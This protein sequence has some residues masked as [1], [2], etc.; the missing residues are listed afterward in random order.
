[1]ATDEPAYSEAEANE[2]LSAAVRLAGVE[3]VNSEELIR[4]AAEMGITPAEVVLAEE[5][6]RE[7]QSEAAHRKHFRRLQRNEF[8]VMLLTEGVTVA[9]CYA[10]VIGMLKPTPLEIA[11]YGSPALVLLFLQVNK[12]FNERSSAYC[13][14]FKRWMEAK[15]NPLR[16]ERV[17]AVVEDTLQKGIAKHPTR[18]ELERTLRKAVGYDRVRAREAL[19]QYLID[20]PEA[21]EK[22]RE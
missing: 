15:K 3:S 4:M 20:H 7:Q 16:P 22:I 10:F 19:H 18:S 6:Y 1:M 9:I 8:V 12:R 17:Q 5:R 14:A 2:I 13:Y 21:Q 11:I